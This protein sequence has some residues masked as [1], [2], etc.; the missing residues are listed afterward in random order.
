MVQSADS[1][2]VQEDMVEQY[3]DSFRGVEMW[4]LLLFYYRTG[5]VESA[6]S[7]QT[8]TLFY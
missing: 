7:T 2:H 8:T 4:A 1:V 5:R 3:S 6:A